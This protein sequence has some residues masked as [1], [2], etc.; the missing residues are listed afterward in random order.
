MKTI[1]RLVYRGLLVSAMA[2]S[3]CG[4]GGDDVVPTPVNTLWIVSPTNSDSYQTESTSVSLSGGAFVPV[5]ANCTGIV[6]TMPSGYQVVWS[7]TANGTSGDANF[8]LGCL[9]QVNVIWDTWP[10]P[11]ALG[12]NPI[13]VTASD[14][15]GHTASDTI[16]VTRLPG[17]LALASIRLPVAYSCR[18]VNAQKIALSTQQEV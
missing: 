4:G 10:I 8:Y 6:G 14:S 5:G 17:L 3:A 11:L 9:L 16:V 7:N 15:S 1:K 13:T 12:S 18:E 2:F